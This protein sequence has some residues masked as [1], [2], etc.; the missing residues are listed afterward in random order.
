MSRPLV[1]IAL[2]V[3]FVCGLLPLALMLARIEPADV[4]GLADVRTL[5]LLG[6][7]LWLGGATAALASL[8]GLPF[9]FLVARAD[10]PG[11][12]W[13]RTLGTVPL[14]LPPLLL[15]M[16]WAVVWTGLRGASGTIFM[17]TLSTFPLVAIFSARAFER[18]DA[19]AEEAALI[20]GGLRAVLRM[21]LPLVLP[22]AAT[23]ACLAFVFAINDFG[24]PDYVSSVGP[25][26]NVYADEVKLNWDQIGEPGKAVATSLPLILVTLAALL[27]ALVLRRR[28]SMASLGERFRPPTTLRLGA[29]RWPAAAFALLLLVAAVFVPVLRLAWE[30][31]AMPQQLQSASGLAA[32]AQGLARMRLELGNALELARADLGRSL[33]Y[34]SSAALLCVPVG[35]VLGH[36]IERT[37]SRWFGRSLEALCVLPIAA[38]ALLFGIGMITTWNH[39]WS[40]RF[41]DGGGMAV[42]LLFSRF[43]PFAV[44]VSSGA[45]ASLAPSLEEA[46]ALAGARPA[47]RLFRIVAPTLRGSLLASFV[48]VFVFSMRDLDSAILIPAA[49]RTAIFRVFNGVHFGRDSYVAALALL[50]VFATVLPAVL[51]SL[52]GRKRL[53]LLP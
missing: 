21:E 33:V 53:E 30:A 32:L 19:S 11:A 44:L 45:V 23:G 7:T 12:S 5:S 49:N 51:Y 37:R 13:M 38:P 18:I 43:L 48:L 16:T 36:A 35:L 1:S 24:V 2:L 22:A 25:K 34:S 31:A 39:D 14:L 27:P 8:L 47:R 20:A 15:A 10:V 3:L 26:F 6:R 9:G 29:A 52:F 28:G 42:L 46:G 50:L 41:Y 17:L 4:A 40:A